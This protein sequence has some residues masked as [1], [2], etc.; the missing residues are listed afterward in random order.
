MKIKYFFQ[1]SLKKIESSGTGFTKMLHSLSVL[2]LAFDWREVEKHQCKRQ[3][4]IEMEILCH[5]EVK[6]LFRHWTLNVSDLLDNIKAVVVL[7]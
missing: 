4:K 6:I 5:C 7:D 3:E 2:F 1:P